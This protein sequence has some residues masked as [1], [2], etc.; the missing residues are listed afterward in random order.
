V[1]PAAALLARLR[2][3]D[4][5]V[6]VD[7]GGGLR[8]SAPKG[9][10]TSEL[11]ADLRRLKPEIIEL[12]RSG[13]ATRARPTRM[14]RA[15]DVPLSFAQQRLWFLDQLEPDTSTYSITVRRRLRGPLDLKSLGSAL[16]ELVGR[17][18]SLRTT[19]VTRNG[20]PCQQIAEPAP[21]MFEVVDLEHVPEADR[22]QSAAE[23]IREEV[24][25]PFNLTRGPLFRPLVLRRAVDDHELVIS[26]HHI[27][28]D[29]WSLGVIA[30]ELHTLYEAH[31]AGMVP[32]LPEIP[33]QYADFAIWQR[34]WLANDVLEI[35]RQYWRKQLAGLPAPLELQT[36]QPRSRDSTSAG[37]SFDFQIPAGLADSLRHLGRAEGT[38]LFMTLLAGFKTMLARYTGAEDI[39]IGTPVAN[40]NHVELEAIVGFF[41]NTLVLRTDLAGDPTFREILGRVREVSL[42]AYTHQD[43][44]FE[45]LV[46]ELRP[47][48]KLGQ[49]PFFQLSFVFQAP[50]TATGF[51]FMTVASPFDLT[52]FVRGGSEGPL[53]ATIEYRRDLFGPQTIARLARCYLTLLEGVAADPDLRLSAL[54]LVDAAEAHRMLIEWN[55]TSTDYP[56]DRSLHGLFEDQVDAT[57]DAV[58]VVFGQTALTYRELDRRANRLAHHLVSLGVGPEQAVGVWMERSAETIVALLGI[59]KAGGAYAPLDSMAPPDR[60]AFMLRDAEIDILVTQDRMLGRL[61]AHG[62]RT[63]CL[64]TEPRAIAEQPNT[65]PSIDGSS[66]ALAYVMYT[67]GST[68]EP[69]GV[70]VTHR[71][72]ARLVRGTDYADFGPGEVFLQLAPL[73]FDAS[74]FEIWGAL[75]NG[76]RL[77]IATPGLLSV[78]ELGTMLERHGVTTLW[79]TAGLFHQ[80]VDQRIDILRSV[81]QLLAGGDVLSPSHVRRVRATLPS[82]RLINGY[83]P[84]EGTTFTCC[85]Q[86]TSDAG[87]A[88]S[89][90]IGRPIP[91]TRVYVLDRNRQP[92]PLGVPGELWVGGDGV[93]RGYLNRPELTAEKFVAQAVAGGREERLYRSGDLV[94][95]LPDGVLEF[96]GRLDHQVKLRG[97]RIE[98]GEIESTIAGHPGV[99]AV[100]VTA[101]SDWEGDKRLVAYVVAEGTLDGRALRERVRSKLP[102]YM[103]PSAFVAIDRL[104][105]TANG[106]VD[107]ARLPE[108]KDSREPTSAPS[109]PRDEVERKLLRIWEE[110]LGIDRIGTQD[111]F[112]DLGGH[113]LSALRM[114]VR[115]EQDLGIRLPIATLFQAPTVQGLSEII[116]A[117][118]RSAP[119]RSLV[120]IQ[121]DGSRRPVFAVP[122]VGGNVLCY[123]DLARFLPSDQP[124]YGLQSRGLDGTEKAL[125]LVEDIAAS[126]LAEVREVQPHGP[127]ALIG[128]CMGGVVA[129]EMAQ[130]LHLAGEKVDLL[131]L[132]E[133]WHPMA[134]FGRRS[135]ASAAAEALVSLIG[136][137]LR[138]YFQELRLRSGRQQIA[139]LFGRLKMLAQMTV[140]RDMF[141]G[142][143]SEFD[144][145]AVTNANLVAFQRYKARAYPGRAVLFL[146]E[147][148]AMPAHDDPRLSW[149]QFL[150]GGAEIHTV[151]GRDSGS[152]LDEPHV[153]G[154]AKQLQGCIDRARRSVAG[155]ERP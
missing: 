18:E 31:A 141:R 42:G 8:C 83:G 122:G 16:T 68:G 130:Q 133:T 105:L 101:R 38:T 35:L 66:D 21:V 25:R 147:S 114:F 53:G 131:A 61:P 140:R 103:V 27:V 4:V 13:G 17:H 63:I 110:I 37:A 92:V 39:V 126:F 28:A 127:Y 96:L 20:E 62:A 36:D 29:G 109:E 87:L 9:V 73:S 34:Q 32:R 123:H 128:T 70:A 89:V 112:F 155:V 43:M 40:R 153:Q 64:D 5:K 108:P 82:C 19:F 81:R 91:N 136:S 151:P 95:W 125:N 146:A 57:P 26:I 56:R 59:L 71:N 88:R 69:K 134:S 143:R 100:A 115:L 129:Y 46:E 90:P 121:P 60:L 50:T 120:A 84:T 22:E 44:P 132:L 49:N 52:L 30:R 67:S 75:L 118:G 55:T 137:R 7:G 1:T 145:R 72:V 135:R 113:S 6:T 12:L 142:D 144:Q 51:D 48:R 152:M 116:R 139:Y 99:R 3:L 76:G 124:F 11:Q 107:R 41:A 77:A 10:L 154:L 98:L 85:Y 148:R 104:P 102:E 149:R 119:R 93:A 117:G 97:Y 23:R 138:L 94:R 45:K 58:A 150:A 86:I 24:Q 106:K 15:G 111:N 78:D 2:A 47:E 74:T 65:R 33:V 54:P 79:L 80:V 14:L